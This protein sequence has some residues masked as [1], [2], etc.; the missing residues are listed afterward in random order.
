MVF[1]KSPTYAEVV[2]RVR[3]VLK[4]MDP[5]DKVEFDGM[6]FVGSGYRPRKKRKNT[7]HVRVRL[8]GM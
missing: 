6:Y 3:E 4:W 7:N 1:V 8:G 2:A 5:R